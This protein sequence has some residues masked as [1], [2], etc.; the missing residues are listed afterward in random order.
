MKIEWINSHKKLEFVFL[1]CTHSWQRRGVD[2]FVFVYCERN[3]GK[4]SMFCSDFL[5]TERTTDRKCNVKFSLFTPNWDS[6]RETQL[7]FCVLP[8]CVHRRSHTTAHSLTDVASGAIFMFIVW[9][10]FTYT[11]ANKEVFGKVA[12]LRDSR[13]LCHFTFCRRKQV[14]MNVVL[15]AIRVLCISE[16][17]YDPVTFVNVKFTSDKVVYIADV[18]PSFEV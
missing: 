1:C 8:K 15:H 11:H 9:N 14:T 4:L 5:S 12:M 16:C 3:D 6:L 17:T 2:E 10:D 13:K 7:Q 18:F